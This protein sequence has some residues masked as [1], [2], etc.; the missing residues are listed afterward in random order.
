MEEASASA[1]VEMDNC[2]L[3]LHVVRC[4][5]KATQNILDTFTVAT[6]FYFQTA[7][8]SVKVPVSSNFLFSYL[9]L[10]ITL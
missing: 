2:K 9:I 1:T 6:R 5:C 3:T 10:Y 4:L 7:K 8:V